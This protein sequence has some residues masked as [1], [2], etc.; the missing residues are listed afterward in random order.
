MSFQAGAINEYM[1]GAVSGARVLH[2]RL[3][4]RGATR[5][6]GVIGNA[7]IELQK[8]GDGS[9]KSFGLPQG[10]TLDRTDGQ[11]RLDRHV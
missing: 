6:R 3:Q 4:D 9:K 10:Q 7:N 11:R 8:P 2:G 1:Y 5:Q